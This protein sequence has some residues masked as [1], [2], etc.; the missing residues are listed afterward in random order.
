MDTAI[1]QPGN[2]NR[3]TAIRAIGIVVLVPGLLGVGAW[4]VVAGFSWSY[5]SVSASSQA[6]DFVQMGETDPQ[7]QPG[8]WT[9][10]NED[11]AVVWWDVKDGWPLVNKPNAHAGGVMDCDFAADGRLAT[12]GR[13]G[14]IKI[15]SADG[16][17]QKSFPITRMASADNTSADATLP[18]GV[19]L[20]PT[21]VAITSDGSTVVVGDTGVYVRSHEVR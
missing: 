8:L 21:R 1:G 19:R 4:G 6:A 14:S 16:N 11:G 15:W 9:A 10:W 7:N 20:L 3:G 17:Q 12:C 5:G 18:P 13:D 2:R